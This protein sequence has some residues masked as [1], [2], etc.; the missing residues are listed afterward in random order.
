MNPYAHIRIDQNEL[1]ETIQCDV[2]LGF[3]DEEGDEIIICD[4]CQAATH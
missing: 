1:N 4:L 3:E 2:C